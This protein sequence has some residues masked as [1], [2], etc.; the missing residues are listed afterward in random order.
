VF[1]D[2]L[3]TDRLRLE[4]CC[5]ENVSVREFYEAASHRNPNIEEITEH[6]SWNPHESMQD[7]R[8][9]LAH[10]EETWEAGEIATY[11]IR[12]RDGEDGAGELAGTC[13]LT[14]DWD[15]DTAT[16]GVWLDKPF[17]G[18]GY[19]GERADTLLELAFDHLDLG[20][21]AVTHHADNENS[22]RAVAKY[23]ERHGGRREGLLRNHAETAD[24]PVDAVRYTVSSEEWMTANGHN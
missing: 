20:M 8:G 18:R 24:G 16:L 4:R 12:P 15:R 11:A 10:F 3:T 6:L 22:E 17:W 2:V 14:C 23:V 5:R 21:V 1:P 9:T 7:S 13:G 19:S